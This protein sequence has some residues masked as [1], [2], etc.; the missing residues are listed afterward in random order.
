MEAY[1]IKAG[2]RRVG[3]PASPT[4]DQATSTDR[5]VGGLSQGVKRHEKRRR[6]ASRGCRGG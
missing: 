1:S 6:G 3:H 4:V 5:Q 2:V